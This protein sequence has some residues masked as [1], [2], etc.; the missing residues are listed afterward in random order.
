MTYVTTDKNGDV[1]VGRTGLHKQNKAI[2]L[3]TMF[4]AAVALVMSP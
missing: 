2:A 3:G 1:E 4:Q